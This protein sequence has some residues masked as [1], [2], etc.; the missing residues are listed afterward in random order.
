M[1]CEVLSK[2][3]DVIIVLIIH[4]HQLSIISNN[5]TANDFPQILS[6]LIGWFASPVLL[7]P[8][9]LLLGAKNDS[10]LMS[11]MMLMKMSLIKMI[12]DDNVGGC[13]TG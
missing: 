7:M 3:D 8:A 6:Y 9:I 1:L 12:L 13:D 10:M 11:L 4:H 5:V 2:K